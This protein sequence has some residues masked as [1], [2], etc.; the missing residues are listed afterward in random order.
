MIVAE[1]SK[2]CNGFLSVAVVFNSNARYPPKQGVK[3]G[4]NL[5][6]LAFWFFS[7]VFRP[8]K[9]T[10]NVRV[11]IIGEINNI[12]NRK[13]VRE[14]VADVGPMVLVKPLLIPRYKPV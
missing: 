3:E 12:G 10:S 11:E 1:L 4:K 14:D 7:T 6:R 9:P 2:V 13:I 5:E 8:T